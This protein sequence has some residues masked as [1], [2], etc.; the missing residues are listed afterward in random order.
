[1]TLKVRKPEL[2]S[3]IHLR[4]GLLIPT[5]RSVRSARILDLDLP[6]FEVSIILDLS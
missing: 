1:M 5:V 6:D 3:S 4:L 2:T